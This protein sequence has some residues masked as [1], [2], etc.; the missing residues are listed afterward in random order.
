MNRD[1][2]D[3]SIAAGVPC[4]VV[5]KFKDYKGKIISSLTDEV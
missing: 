5:R 1:I 4:R 3:G 2:S